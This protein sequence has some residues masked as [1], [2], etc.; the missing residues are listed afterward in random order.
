MARSVRLLEGAGRGFGWVECFDNEVHDGAGAPFV[1][2]ETQ[3]VA[4]VIGGQ[5]F[6]HVG[7]LARRAGGVTFPPERQPCILAKE[8]R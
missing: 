8:T 1:A 3:R 5:T 6:E 4:G 7:R 2:D